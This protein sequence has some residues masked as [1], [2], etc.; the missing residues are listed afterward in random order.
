MKKNREAE[1]VYWEGTAAGIGAPPN[2]TRRCRVLAY[3]WGVE[4][5]YEAS[6]GEWCAARPEQAL[7][8]LEAAGAH[9][10]VQQQLK[11]WQTIIVTALVMDTLRR[12]K[13]DQTPAE[14]RETLR[15]AKVLAPHIVRRVRGLR[16]VAR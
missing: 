11:E 16:V 14:A 15:L 4:V 9:L 7:K 8:V 6:D 10:V 13:R 3:S 1:T 12:K 5:S 2:T